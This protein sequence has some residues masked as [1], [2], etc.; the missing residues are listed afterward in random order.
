MKKLFIAL[1]IILVGLFT[2]ACSSS[3]DDAE[4]KVALALTG[5]KTDGGWNQTAYNGLVKIEEE[6][7]ATT[8]Y[9]ENVK[10][11]DYE[12]VLRDY[13]KDG[14]NVVIG[15]GYEFSDAA[16][17]VGA[18]YP[19]VQFIVT[20]T[21]V[22]NDDNVGSLNNNY[23]EQGFLQGAFAAM[24]TSSNV[25]GAVGGMQIPPIV[26]DIAG[27]QAGVKYI[28]P[29]VKV[30]SALTGSFDDANMAKEQALAFIEQGADYVMTDAD[31]AGRGVYVAAEEKAV[32]A[33]GSIAAEY[34][35]YP[36]SLIATATSDMATA[37]YEN[38]KEIK[39]AGDDYVASFR[40]MGIEDGIVDF[41]F[42]PELESLIPD[43]VVTKIDTIKE[44]LV[45]GKI[46][47]ES[48]SAEFQ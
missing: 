10:A 12:R 3:S 11:S 27:F 1:T 6:L 28:N 44:D 26:N 37:I 45:S 32:M 15:H 48:L 34:E 16:L 30:L 4:F 5:A 31:H 29:D 35:D 14:Y 13:A 21:D 46:D 9:S 20:S 47:V 41:T 25:V 24:M 43:D 2:V 38:V 19:D 22:T 36:K 33:I 39:E 42:N 40:L 8:A 23:L 18:E 17:A 7:G